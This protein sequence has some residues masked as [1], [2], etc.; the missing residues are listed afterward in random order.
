MAYGPR[1]IRVCRGR[2]SVAARGRH[3]GRNQTESSL[4]MSSMEQRAKWQ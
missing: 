2:G 1:G 4:L 3:G